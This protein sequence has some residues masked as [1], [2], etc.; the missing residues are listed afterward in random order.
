MRAARRDFDGIPAGR[1]HAHQAGQHPLDGVGN[2]RG[3]VA[4]V[5]DLGRRP[6]AFGLRQVGLEVAQRSLAIC[7]PDAPMDVRRRSSNEL[8]EVLVAQLFGV[9]GHCVPERR[10]PRGS[11]S[12]G[13]RDDLGRR[14]A[15]FE[16]LPGALAQCQV[17]ALCSSCI[18]A[19][20]PIGVSEHSQTGCVPGPA[21]PRRDGQ[22]PQLS[23]H[24]Q[25]LRHVQHMQHGALAVRHAQERSL[26]ATASAAAAPLELVLAWRRRRPRPAH[27]GALKHCHQVRAPRLRLVA[28][29]P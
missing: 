24:R 15:A 28:H 13:L 14:P 3:Q 22:H 4:A 20:N 5:V 9:G 16:G 10:S 6:L 25:S 1:E 29:R 17:P 26:H 18:D 19:C 23:G 2:V 11:V 12:G 27:G 21:V 8:A 7:D